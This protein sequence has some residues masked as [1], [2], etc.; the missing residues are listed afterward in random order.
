MS[1]NENNPIDDIIDQID[2]D[3]IDTCTKCLCHS[4]NLLSLSCG[5]FICLT[6]I[7]SLIDDNKYQ[8]CPTCNTVL[9]KNLH[10][11]YT[12]FLADPVA[13]LAYY[14][15][16]HIGDILWWYGGNG[17][18]WLYSKDQCAQLNT[19][20]EIYDESNN[21]DDSLVELQIQTGNTI[22]TYV[23]DF[24]NRTQ[25]PKNTPNKQRPISCF[26]FKSASDLKKNKIIGIAGKL[27]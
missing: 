18:N 9:T 22:H 12:Q 14:H 2:Q 6:C 17:H 27:L 11:M 7:E 10:I 15:D 13:K 26:K 24:A 3:N 25:Y 4:N 5:H 8:N 16:I 21:D 23:V 20:F 19:A 1:S